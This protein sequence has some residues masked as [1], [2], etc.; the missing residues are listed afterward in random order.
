[1]T[2]RTGQRKIDR[3]D[4]VVEHLRERWGDEPEAAPEAFVRHFYRGVPPQD[5]APTPLENLYGA[6]VSAW[7]FMAV[8]K[9]GRAKI[10]IY[11]P[12]LEEHGWEEPQTILEI[13][14]DDMPFLVDSVTAELREMGIGILL[15]VHP[16]FGVVRD[17]EGRL[18]EVLPTA[19]RDRQAH[20]ESLMQIHVA[21]QA[22]ERMDEIR[23]RLERVLVKVGLAVSDWPAMTTRC[24]EL[25]EDLRE[26]GGPEGDEAADFL[27]WLLEDHFTFVGYREY[28]WRG[29]GSETRG[30]VRRGSGLGILHDRS[31]HVFD[32]LL[33]RGK[34][35]P[36]VIHYISEPQALKVTKANLRSPVHRPVLLDAIA[37]KQRDEAGNPVSSSLF[38]GLF[39]SRAYAAMPMEIP[40]L[41]WKVMRVLAKADV[42][43]TT[44]DGRALQHI[45][46]AFP[47]DALF[48]IDEAALVSTAL[49]ILDLQER[50]RTALFAQ[51]D[52]FE[53]WVSCLVYTPRDRFDTELRQRMQS[54]LT[55]AWNGRLAAYTTRIDEVPLARLHVSIRTTPGEVPRVDPAEVEKALVDAGRTWEDRLSDVLIAEHGEPEGAALLRRYGTAFPAAYRDFFHELEA[56]A[57]IHYVERAI[58]GRGLDLNLYRPLEAPSN[59]LRFKV[60]ATGP[61]RPLSDVLP[62]LENMGFRIVA[63]EPFRLRLPD[64]TDPVW[65]RD[66]NLESRTSAPIDLPRIRDRFHEAFQLVWKGELES[67]GFN[68]L[69]VAAGLS[70]RQVTVLR[71]YCRYLQQARMP[72]SQAYVEQTLESQPEIAHKLVE[73]FETRFDPA[74]QEGADARADGIIAE[75]RALLDAVSNLDMDR[76]IRRYMVVIGATLRTNYYQRDADG[77]PKPYL[78]LKLDSS[79]IRSLPLPRPFREIF[80]HS[81]RMEGVHLRGG[82]V[83]RGGIRWSDRPEDFRT[84]VLGLMKAQM[85]KNTVIVP[86]GS[87]GGFIVKRLP[88]ATAGREA[89]QKAVVAGYKTLI[90]GLLDLTDNLDGG[91]VKPPERVVRRDEDDPYLVVAAD[92]GTA[93]FSD[94]ANG[95]A[96]EYGFWLG[97]AFASGGS[98]GYDHK[99]MAITARGTWECVKRHFREIGKDIQTEPFTVVGVG[100]MAGDVFGNGMLLSEKIRLVAAF[101]HQHVFLDPDPDLAASFT[102]RK[103]L[104]DLPRSTWDDYDRSLLSE[105]GGIYSR[106]LK[107]IRVSPRVREILH[108]EGEELTP[109]ELIHAMLQAPVELL[110]FGGIGTYVKASTERNGEV[111]DRANDALRIDGFELRAQVVGEG[112]NLGLTQQGRIEAAIGGV[113]LNT[114]ALDNS[115]GVDCSDHEVNIKVLL[116]EAERAGDLTRKRRDHILV[117]MTDEVGRLVLRD[118]YLQSQAITVAQQKGLSRLDRLGRF[119]RALEKEGRLDREIE[120]LPDD[121]T[122]VRRMKDRVGLT[123]P[124]LAVL[125]AYAKIAVYDELLPSDL[126]EEEWTGAELRRYFPEPLRETFAERIAE[127]RLHREILA[128]MVTNAMLNRV[129]ITFVHEMKERTGLPADEV[130]RA[131]LAAR[132]VLQLPPLYASIEELDNRVPAALQAEM[133]AEASGA[134]EQVVAWMLRELPRP[135]DVV[136]TVERFGSGVA[137][138]TGG[139]D[140]LLP[141][142]HHIA[143]ERQ[144]AAYVSRGAPA[145]LAMRVAQL[146]ALVPACQIVRI[147]DEAGVA[148]LRAAEVYYAVGE[149]FGFDWLHGIAAE[150]PVDSAWDKLAVTSVVDDLY[151]HQATIAAHALAVAPAGASAMEAMASWS[152]SL[153]PLVDRTK[154]LFAE[155]ASVPRP[156]LAM[157][158]VAVQQLK[159]LTL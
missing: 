32:G 72:F 54:I 122:L 73:L 1:M 116:G 159:A 85:V 135:I 60:Y 65:I 142:S 80:V 61:L 13:L 33:T 131:F 53:R 125:L 146:E 6:V 57:D 29:R 155:L 121:A 8:R 25:A 70:A 5:I 133:L 52:P 148:S 82:K 117:E 71:A 9:P 110:W 94:I 145:P 64:V 88:P 102:E 22:P 47:R 141:R 24:R 92:K 104:F 151:G 113:R 154:R 66:L 103:R 115:A 42:A 56:V 20:A 100:D 41:R 78:S 93:T 58:A 132:D 153:A 124:E 119:M 19:D 81:A 43:P 23:D 152:E 30:A 44:H 79:G 98:A 84:E 136:G 12:H 31:V 91:V 40:A 90:R 26:G 111:G 143:C 107:A 69:V 95:V 3:I 118:N 144:A 130:A 126:P 109:N 147:A 140:T 14:N 127:H 37:V 158:T 45:L 10:R 150:L 77:C 2:A 112:A 134:V 21:P 105:G 137:E 120:Y 62:M 39:T 108:L 156:D 7:R 128:T 46:T 34:L 86:V 157:L 48:Q 28:V 96:G 36:D 51:V 49:G 15:V 50:P 63:E 11:A 17:D 4:A 89:V 99:K 138:L 35:A 75:I 67:D 74:A 59:A 139:L 129:G 101:N 16:V 83:A 97:D 87:K 38:V 123:R 76:I 68:R 106:D 55:K 149:A 114:D 18:A 27:E